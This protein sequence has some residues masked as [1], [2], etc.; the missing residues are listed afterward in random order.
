MLPFIHVFGLE[1]PMYGICLAA[2]M[3]SGI[4]LAAQLRKMTVVKEDDYY[5]SIITILLSGLLGAKILYLIVEFKNVIRNPR[6]YLWESIGAGFV[7]Y[8]GIVLGAIGLFI[9][10]RAKRQSYFVYTDLITTGVACGQILGRVGCFC[11]GCCYGRKTDSFLGVVF[12]NV[13][14]ES[15]EAVKRLPTQLFETAFCIILTIILIQCI[16]KKKTGLATS[17]YCIGYGIWR[18]ILEYLRDDERG[19]V[20]VLSTS[21]FISIFIVLIGILLLVLVLKGKIKSPVPVAEAETE[22]PAA[23]E[24]SSDENSENTSDEPV[25]KEESTDKTN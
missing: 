13:I 6:F 20:G 17:G 22:I 9:Y 4:L 18:F 2:G 12:P 25:V 10:C 19:T 5:G 14:E 1:I 7:F 16:K 23:Y 11:A 24:L 8:G 3:I 15:G 21:Q